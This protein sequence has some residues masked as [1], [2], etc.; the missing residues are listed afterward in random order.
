MEAKG[1]RESE[2]LPVDHVTWEI[3]NEFGEMEE[4]DGGQPDLR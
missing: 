4:E 3:T 2:N 1:P